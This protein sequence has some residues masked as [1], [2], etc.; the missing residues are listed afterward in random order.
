MTE[1]TTEVDLVRA[2]IL[3]AGGATLGELGLEQDEI[4]QRGVR[5]AVP[6]DDGEPGQGVPAGFRADH[7]VPLAGRRGD[8]SRRGVGV[9][10]R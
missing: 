7:G 5:V 8:P 9:R 2:Q 3:I 6:G 1:E 4:R 10:R